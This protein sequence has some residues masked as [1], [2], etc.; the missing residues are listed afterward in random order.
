MD[1]TP[2]IKGDRKIV[3]SYGAGRFIINGSEYTHS[4][5][6][7]PLRVVPWEAPLPFA[8]S[9]VLVESL[10][11]AAESSDSPEVLLVGSGKNMVPLPSRLRQVFKEQKVSIDVMDTGAACRTYNVLLSEERRVLAALAVV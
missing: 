8:W 3:N 9:E 1:I 5:I 4:L 6:V 7:S 2:L 11:Q 10:L